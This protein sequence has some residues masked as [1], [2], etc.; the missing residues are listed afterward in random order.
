MAV[1]GKTFLV[2]GGGGVR[3]LAHL[4][5]LRVLEEVGVRIDGI[6]G[7]SAGALVGALYARE[8]NANAVIAQALGFLDSPAF[9]RLNLRFDLDG[10]PNGERPSLVNRFVHGL[11][12]QL[13][14][15][16]LFRRPSMFRSTVL[17]RLVEALIGRLDFE[18]LRV[19]LFVTALDLKSGAEVTLQQGSL[20]DAI[21]A[22]SSVPGFFPPR[23]VGPWLLSDAGLFNNMPIAVARSL[24]A[25]QVIAVS[26]NNRVLPMTDFPT[27]IDVIFRNEEIGTK[28]VNDERKRSAS[29]VIEPDISGR[30]WL[31]FRNCGEVVAAGE[32]AARA[33]IDDLLE[34]SRSSAA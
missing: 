25:Q 22:S 21:I 13:A 16:L 24:G 4:G 10:R 26:L 1:G 30:Y 7:T 3:G 23:A 11:K 29:L 18:D 6:V 20:L 8:P 33:R 31:D 28:L 32:A 2:L 27:G 9:K 17:E 15:E 19:P 34:L 5:V 12:K 14:M